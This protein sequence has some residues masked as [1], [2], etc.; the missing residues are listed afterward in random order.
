MTTKEVEMDIEVVVMGVIQEEEDTK[1]D[2]EKQVEDVVGALL[3]F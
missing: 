2:T 1:E 3:L